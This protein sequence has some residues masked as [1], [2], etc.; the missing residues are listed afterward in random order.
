MNSN[1]NI[2][3]KLLSIEQET[4]N[5]TLPLDLDEDS[6]SLQSQDTDKRKLFPSE[7]FEIDS[8]E[9]SVKKLNLLTFLVSDTPTSMTKVPRDSK[10]STPTTSIVND[11]NKQMQQQVT[12]RKPLHRDNSHESS[13]KEVPDVDRRA[14]VVCSIPFLVCFFFL[15]YDLLFGISIF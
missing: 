12:E 7:T 11:S 1:F 13:D 4:R 5:S 8:N 15:L 9:I 3:S 6:S 14:P 10:E 2:R